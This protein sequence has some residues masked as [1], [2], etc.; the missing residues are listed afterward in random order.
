MKTNH[1][2]YE[3]TYDGVT[4]QRAKVKSEAEQKVLAEE[5]L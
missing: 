5:V 2:N 3:D 1:P 4:A